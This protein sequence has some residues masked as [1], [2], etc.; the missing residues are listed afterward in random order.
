MTEFVEQS[1]GG[2]R[3]EMREVDGQNVCEPCMEGQHAHPF[4]GQRSD[5]KMTDEKDE[6]G[7]CSCGL[8]GKFYDAQTQSWK[9]AFDE[10]TYE[11]DTSVTMSGKFDL[12]PFEIRS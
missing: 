6:R 2:Y 4:E 8:G 7:Q 9:K 5:C 12:Q 3:R 11:R 1:G 10:D